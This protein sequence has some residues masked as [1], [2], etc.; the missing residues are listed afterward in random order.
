MGLLG[1]EA[2]D[3]PCGGREEQG[4]ARRLEG[5]GGWGGRGVSCYM[6]LQ[7]ASSASQTVPVG[8]AQPRQLSTLAEVA[9]GAGLLSLAEAIQGHSKA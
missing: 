1:G 5:C 6:K 8:S 7:E 2:R 3:A 9:D 4:Q